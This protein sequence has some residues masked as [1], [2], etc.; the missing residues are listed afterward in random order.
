MITALLVIFEVLLQVI[1]E[2]EQPEH[3]KHDKKFDDDYNPERPPPGHV[4]E[5]IV[6]EEEYPCENR[7]FHHRRI[8]GHPKLMDNNNRKQL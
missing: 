4:P 8:L 5:A 7:A 6:I 1:R 2:K 3:S